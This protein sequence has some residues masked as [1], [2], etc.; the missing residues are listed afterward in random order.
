MKHLAIILLIFFMLSGMACAD[1]AMPL[2]Y[3]RTQLSILHQTAAPLPWQAPGTPASVPRYTFDVEVR[4]AMTIYNQKG[5]F[6]LSSPQETNGV[7][8]V[9]AAP[10]QAPIIPSSQYAPVDILMIDREGKILQI[11]P[12]L[13]LSELEEDIYPERPVLAFLFL[14]GGMCE[15]LS[16]VPGDLVEYKIFRKPPMVLTAPPPIS[17]PPVEPAETH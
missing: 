15:R 16:I 17:P 13:L 10:A 7:L 1:E 11:V 4:D 12:K 14:K 5:W 6:N 8:L 2:L 9:F 3:S